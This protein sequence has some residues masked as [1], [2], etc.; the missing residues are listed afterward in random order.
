MMRGPDV[1]ATAVRRRDGSVVVNKQPVPHFLQGHRWA[2]LP[3]I[4]GTFLLLE[5]L[6]LGL[7]SLQ[8][9]GNVA[10]QD[11]EQAAAEESPPQ[12]EPATRRKPWLF[13]ALLAAVA[14]A[15]IVWV[16]PRFPALSQSVPGL[17]RA[18]WLYLVRLAIGAFTV[19]FV[20]QLL[21]A[22][23]RPS[24]AGPQ[25]VSDTALW[26]TM[27][28]ALALG[29]GL[30]ILLPTYL[31]GLVRA[32][33]GYGGAIAK[34]VIE[35]ALRL[36]L[37]LGYIAVISLVGQVR[38]VFQYHGAEHKTINALEIEGRA[39]PET[40]RRQSPLH[41]R[42][43]TAFLLLFI[44][45]KIIV[46]WFFGWPVWYWRLA[47]RLLMVPVVAALAYEAT[48]LAGRHRD[49]LLA[50]IISGPGLLLQRMTTREPEPQMIDVALYALAAVA[51]EV[52]LPVG[53]P[54]AAQFAPA[55]VEAEKR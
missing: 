48:R 14:V 17:H 37:I 7:R 15:L 18:T 27:M 52:P 34:N 47:L 12:A 2:K 40:A 13:V 11:E 33:E 16:T 22:R 24:A 38:R 23:P 26:L 39:D 50:R 19:A 6:T 55:A 54:P 8:F 36:G 21:T 53:W 5:T 41:P 25:T 3:F 32:G 31:A 1:Y 20:V 29:V 4:R 30:F 35:G 9:S 49:S 42:C 44:V 51:P 10:L 28:P 46:G 43:G 45:L